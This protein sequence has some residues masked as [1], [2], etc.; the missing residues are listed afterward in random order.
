MTVIQPTV[1]RAVWFYANGRHQL[2]AGVQPYSAHIA[3]VWSD[4]LINIGFL[5]SNGVAKSMTSV[6]LVQEGDSLP[7]EEPFCCW[8]P[9]QVEQAKKQNAMAGI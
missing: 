2:D 1:G 9:F 3:Y 6:K 7:D 4:R 8:M 5:D